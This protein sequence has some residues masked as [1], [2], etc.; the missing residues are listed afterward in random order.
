MDHKG[1]VHLL[2]QK[3]LSGHQARWLVA[4]GDF[5]F[6]VIYIEGTENILAD[7]LSQLYANDTPGT[8]HSPS[9][10]PQH[11]EDSPPPLSEIEGVRITIPLDR[12]GSSCNY[13]SVAF[14]QNNAPNVESLEQT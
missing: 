7:A 9:K 14:W 12:V 8:V 13:N 6:D 4:L 1:L 10:Y 3:Q 5:S 11:D 2:N